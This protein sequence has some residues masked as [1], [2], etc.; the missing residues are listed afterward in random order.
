[1]EARKALSIRAFLCFFILRLAVFSMNEK[2]FAVPV[3]NAAVAFWVSTHTF[4]YVAHIGLN[5]VFVVF[6]G[7]WSYLKLQEIYAYAPLPVF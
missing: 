1:M 2:V 3:G 7:I 4:A 5:A 6:G